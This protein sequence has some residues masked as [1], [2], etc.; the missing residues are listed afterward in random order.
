[1]Y[2]YVLANIVNGFIYAWKSLAKSY[3]SSKEYKLN[4]GNNKVQ[5]HGIFNVPLM[6]KIC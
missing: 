3:K 6:G 2:S 1:M 4:Y 5:I